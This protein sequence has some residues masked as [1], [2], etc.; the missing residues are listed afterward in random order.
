MNFTGR[1]EPRHMTP[2]PSVT[3]PTGRIGSPLPM[4]PTELIDRFGRKHTSLRIS[5]TD[6]C[7]IRCFYC[8]PAGEVTFAPR[9]QL[10]SFE[11]IARIVRILAGVG[12]RDVRLTG[13]E[14][15]VRRDLERLV[16]MLIEIEGVG[17]LALT[18]N[19]IL[20]PQQARPLREAG[21]KRLNISLDTLNEAVFQQITR[22]Q[23]V[24]RV[25]DGI[26]AAVAAGFEAIRLNALAIRGLTEPELEPLVEFAAARGLTL[27]FIEY[28][29]LDADR[30]W[31][32]D[33]VLSG[34]AILDRLRTRFGRL[35][36]LDPPHESQPARDFEL[37]D[38][39]ADA[40]GRHPR[41][42]LIRPVT[43][44]FCGACDRI[45][46]TAEGMV[47]NCLFSHREWDLRQLLRG[48]ASDAEI[49]ETV[50]AAVGAKEAGHLISERGF[51]QP[52]RAMFRIGG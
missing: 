6:R 24:Q 43:E 12:V 31:E 38:L 41:V 18:T 29:P 25:L 28:M 8:M 47:R 50:A 22:R 30:R 15:L 19:G 9:E 44:P 36:P 21:L 42:G 51:S 32:R 14:P 23:G 34:A 37:L 26:D 33:Q 46:L 20:L 40:A 1:E 48:G 5:V 2:L 4:G 17:D 11:E 27:R 7:N 10:L 49:L 13:G 3:L 52:E 35:R 39:P 16:R 45:R